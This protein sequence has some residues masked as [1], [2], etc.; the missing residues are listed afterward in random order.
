MH[1]TIQ[2]QIDSVITSC[3]RAKSLKHAFDVLS[4]LPHTSLNKL[5][6]HWRTNPDYEYYGPELTSALITITNAGLSL[7]VKVDGLPEV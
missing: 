4:W 3:K 1:V 2:D 7:R 5:I 6:M